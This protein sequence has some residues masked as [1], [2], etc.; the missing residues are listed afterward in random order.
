MFFVLFVLLLSLENI[1][2]NT[3]VL[4]S[5][6]DVSPLIAGGYKVSWE[7]VPYMVSVMVYSQHVCGG[8][9]IS[10]KWIL[11]AGYNIL[12]FTFNIDFIQ[13]PTL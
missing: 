3:T 6:Q 10:R 9:I 11:S 5:F 4:D 1:F 8:S 13:T 12:D 2:C 7:R